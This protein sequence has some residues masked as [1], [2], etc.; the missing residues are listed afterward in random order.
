MARNIACSNCKEKVRGWQLHH[1]A[2]NASQRRQHVRLWSARRR[3][4]I[5]LRV[6]GRES[7]RHDGERVYH[8]IGG[9]SLQLRT[10][11]GKCRSPPIDRPRGA[12]RREPTDAT[13][14]RETEINTRANLKQENVL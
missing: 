2:E 1:R 13:E 10:R 8:R 7:A 6:P 3:H 9:N 5:D 4:R 14:V 12:I 11:Q